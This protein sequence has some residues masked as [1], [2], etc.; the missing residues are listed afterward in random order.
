MLQTALELESE[1]RFTLIY[2]NRTKDSTM[3]RPELDELES[4]YS[5]RL[6]ILHVLS[7]DPHAT[8]HLSGR[9]DHDKLEHW[10]I[11][12]FTPNTVDEWFLCGPSS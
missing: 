10:L 11:T 7:R 6:E 9:I 3:F 5:D 2:G 4:R 8:P 12:T 1:S